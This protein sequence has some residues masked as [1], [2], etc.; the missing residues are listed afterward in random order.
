M[1]VNKSGIQQ[2]LLC[3]QQHNIVLKRF[4]WFDRKKRSFFQLSDKEEPRFFSETEPNPL[5]D[6]ERRIESSMEK[7][8]W[9]KPVTR[10]RTF[11]T[12]GLRLLAP[13]RTRHF[14][15]IMQRPLDKTNILRSI[16][17]K[18]HEMMAKDQ[19]FLTDRHRMLGNDLAAAHFLVARGGQVRFTRSKEWIKSNEH[20]E[21]DLPRLYDPEY[22]ID[23]IKCDGMDLMYEGLEN[24]RRLHHLKYFSLR[25]VKLFDDWCMDRLCGNQFD[26]IEILDVSG[27]SITANALFAVPKLRT[28]KAIVM[29][30]ANRSTSFQLACAELECVMP[31]LKILDSADVHDDI[32]EARKL[33]AS[34]ENP[35][36]AK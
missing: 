22:L 19:R 35:A 31:K 1:H 36:E 10:Q 9:R 3:P 8:Q 17:L 33:A 24:V 32:Y 5:S 21:Y 27:T 29:D 28:L 25:D 26:N 11:L 30:T 23:A 7:L 15:E 13:E 14:L 20:D 12:E 34:T 4:G 16:E 18:R 6:V 2:I